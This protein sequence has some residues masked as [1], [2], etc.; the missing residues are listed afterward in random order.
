MHT[1]YR[2]LCLF[3][4]QV[5]AAL[6]C[7]IMQICLIKCGVG[8]RRWINATRDIIVR[9]YGE[10]KIVEK[11]NQKADYSILQS[12]ANMISVLCVS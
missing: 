10:H 6:K 5:T 8:G 11:E 1:S 4:L 12:C 3:D 9:G 7:G 2:R